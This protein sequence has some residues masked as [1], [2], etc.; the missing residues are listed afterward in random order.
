MK[1]DIKKTTKK[2]TKDRCL[3]TFGIG[4]PTP[5]TWNLDIPRR[6]NGNPDLRYKINKVFKLKI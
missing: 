6:K 3:G 5:Y 1:I 4:R 2:G